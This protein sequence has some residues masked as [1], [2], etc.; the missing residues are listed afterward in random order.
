MLYI[1]MIKS[2]AINPKENVAMVLFQCMVSVGMGTIKLSMEQNLGRLRAASVATMQG[3]NTN[4][5]KELH[6]LE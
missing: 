4:I 2:M 3:D 6:S 1:P 5:S